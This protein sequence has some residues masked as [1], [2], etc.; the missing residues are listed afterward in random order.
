MNNQL[1]LQ[2]LKDPSTEVKPMNT[3][4]SD[5]ITSFDAVETMEFQFETSKHNTIKYLEGIEA[6]HFFRERYPHLSLSEDTKLLIGMEE[7][8]LFVMIKNTIRNLFRYIHDFIKKTWQY[9]KN[10]FKNILNIDGRLK[11][12]TD[13]TYANFENLYKA[14]KPAK[15]NKANEIFKEL[16]IKTMG[17]LDQYIDLMNDFNNVT[18]SIQINHDSYIKTMIS[19]IDKKRTESEDPVWLT[20]EDVSMLSHLGILIEGSKA[21]YKS[22]FDQFQD[23][24][25]SLLGFRSLEQIKHL[26]TDYQKKVW[27]RFVDFK[28][29]VDNI[30]KQ[31]EVL[32]KKEREITDYGDVNINAITENIKHLQFQITLVVSLFGALRNVNMS[33][34]FR[35]KRIIE[36]GIRA[37]Q[38]ATGEE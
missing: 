2:I 34:D 3:S 7:S 37:I 14:L 33:I 21:K 38:K 17:P 16:T 19:S 30:Q 8:D 31:E 27:N 25:F 24:Q 9:L 4:V 36:S 23:S 5:F 10:G 1:F 35:R 32:T 26:H 18:Q 6:Y 22:F 20:K 12:D 13:K 11:K 15:L 29:V 28:R